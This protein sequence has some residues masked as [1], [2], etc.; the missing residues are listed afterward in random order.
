MVQLK[1]SSL[2]VIEADFVF[3]ST[4][5]YIFVPYS[6]LN[7]IITAKTLGGKPLGRLA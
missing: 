6:L 1:H 2:I 3:R 5:D 7:K 4:I